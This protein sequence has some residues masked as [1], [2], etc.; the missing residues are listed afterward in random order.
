MESPP[1]P[2]EKKN[3]L[4]AAVKRGVRTALVTTGISLVAVIAGLMIFEDKLIYFPTVGGVGP[5]PSQE[6]E[7][8]A[9][10]RVKLHAWYHPHPQAKATI[11]HLHGN[12][13]NLEDRRDLVRD[14]QALGV[15]VF[16]VEWR[17][18]GKSE[19]K[20]SEEGLYRDAR[21]AWDWLL[22]K[23]TAD[24][25]VIHGESLG[26]GPACE[27]AS[28]VPCAGL[29]LQS[30]FTSIPDMAPRVMPLFPKFLVRTK[31]DNLAKVPKIGCRKLFLHSQADEMIPFDMGRK[32]Y[33]AA[34]EPKECTW[35][36]GIG[37]NEMTISRAK[38]YYSRIAEFLAP[39]GP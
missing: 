13:G 27:L 9:A 35:F 39:F 36:T 7:I 33:D 4:L 23:T 26:G 38:K 2:T 30:T 18:Y 34:S 25:I 16:A 6:V 8:T 10:D 15:N 19:G 22:T 24:K 29:I 5:S 37:H 12:A 1:V 20:P 11:L 17:G 21:A 32:L 3:A 14:L 31:Y 28:T